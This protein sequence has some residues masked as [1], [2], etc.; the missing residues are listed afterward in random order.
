MSTDEVCNSYRDQLALF[1]S[2]GCFLESPKD[3]IH[4]RDGID[5]E[6]IRARQSKSGEV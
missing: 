6:G 3:V 2:L 5:V 4:T 1:E